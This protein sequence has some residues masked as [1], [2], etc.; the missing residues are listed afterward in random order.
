MLAG[1]EWYERRFGPYQFGD[2]VGPVPVSWPQGDI[3]GMEHHPFW[4]VR[5]SSMS[6]ELVQM[7]EAAH[8]WF[9]NGVRLRCWED[10]V[11]AEGTATYLAARALVETGSPEGAEIWTGYESSFQTGVAS[12][13]IVAWPDGCGSLDI[14]TSGLDS[15]LTYLKGALFY[16]A[17]EARIGSD[18]LDNAFATF[19][20]RFVGRAAGMQD[21]L[22]VV[23]ETSGYDPGPC[24]AH[25]LKT[26]QPT[27]TACP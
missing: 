15:N 3:D 19:Y 18:Q 7:H 2:V 27:E 14:L 17:L 24:A 13:S 11:L 26:I 23:K 5:D 25:W 21:L 6:D 22:D 1:F 8:G 20:I 16:R 10:F 12:D 9:G 4:H